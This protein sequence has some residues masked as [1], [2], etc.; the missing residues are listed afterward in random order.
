MVNISNL[1]VSRAILQMIPDIVFFYSLKQKSNT[2]LAKICPSSI[3]P[4]GQM[5]YKTRSNKPLHD[6]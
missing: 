2:K 5:P 4:L 3:T 1:A 6:G